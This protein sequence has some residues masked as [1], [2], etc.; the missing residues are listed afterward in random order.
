MIPSQS[1]RRQFIGG[2]LAGAAGLAAL[3]SWAKPIGANDDVRVAVIGFNGRGSGHI[4]SLN[5]IKGVR[6]VAL[7]DVDDKV[8]E[9][10][11]AN[12]AKKNIKVKQYKDFRECCADPE[13]DAV[14]I[15]TPNHSH[16]LIAM[17]AIA[18]GKHVYV[19]KPVSHNIWEGRQLVDAAAIA[20]RKGLV[21]QHG[22]QRRSSPGWAA[23]MDYVNSGKIGKVTLSRGINFKARKSIGKVAAPVQPKGGRIAGTFRDTGGKP[24]IIDVDYNLW[25]A[26][27]PVMPMQR[28]QFHY[29]WHWQW[30]YGNGDIGNQ[31]PHQLDVA[32]WA[33]GNAALPTRVMSLGGRWGYEDDGQTANNQLAF[34]Q[35]AESAP[36]LFD[37]RGLPMKDMNWTKGYEPVYRINGK[38]AAPRIGNVI[39]CE[40]G[41]VAEAKAYDNDGNAIQKFDNFDEGA[42]HM[43]NF[44]DSVR[45]G[46]L[47][48]SNLHVSHG[49]AAAALA[50]MSN[51]SYRLGKKLS[52]D[53]VKERLANDKA[54]QETFAD[55]VANLEAN[56]IDV[57]AQQCS[58]GPMLEFD[59]KSEKFTGEFAE[60]AN[61]LA[62]DEYAAGF[63]LPKIS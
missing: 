27:R 46:K 16:T 60:E 54:A 21:V 39:H 6:I 13:I 12:F 33:L 2:T 30:A 26:P 34:Y 10:H 22:M 50:Q 49:H 45:A 37:N 55:F 47:V 3:P 31:G 28:E 17:H 62:Q 58:V 51:I 11:V 15:A 59:P 41:F 53:Q 24:Q 44:I 23:A 8:M 14:T 29:D 42:D 19:E 5:G 57:N 35:F 48:N 9:K 40:N 52:V 61:K 63:E 4:G 56:K 43:K 32:R 20:E 25:S 7:C 18:N 1:S 36:L 38:T